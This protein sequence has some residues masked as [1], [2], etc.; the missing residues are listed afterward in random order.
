MKKIIVAAALVGL[1][2]PA[3][4]AQDQRPSAPAPAKG[5]ARVDRGPVTY[6]GQ[7]TFFEMKDYA[8]DTMMID[9]AS[10]SV[11]TDWNIRSL[12]IHPGDRWQICA[13]AGFRDCIVIDRSVA[14][15]SVIGITG[16]I[17]SARPAPA[18]TRGN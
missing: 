14:D 12:S 3:L 17:G 18:E 1:T 16:Q 13:R 7:L 5:Q 10:R 15:A 8:G 11:H 6:G 4:A 9:S 2:V